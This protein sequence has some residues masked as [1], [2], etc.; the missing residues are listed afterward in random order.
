MRPLLVTIT[1]K[2]GY[3]ASTRRVSIGCAALFARH[4]PTK[5]SRRQETEDCACLRLLQAQ[6]AES[7]STNYQSFLILLAPRQ[8]DTWTLG[9]LNF[10]HFSS[11]R[12]GTQ[13]TST[14]IPIHIHKPK[15]M[16]HTH[17]QGEASCIA[18]IFALLHVATPQ[19]PTIE[20]RDMHVTPNMR[21]NP[22]V[23]PVHARTGQ[24]RRFWLQQTPPSEAKLMR[25]SCLLCCCLAGTAHVQPVY[26]CAM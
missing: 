17:A 8:L 4:D 1:R 11:V 26:A 2:E 5:S 3:P 19:S 14:H 7:K 21:S 18:T 15:D 9:Q 25:V 20:C 16:A 23:R 12:S 10:C 24:N 13:I 6:K 22:G